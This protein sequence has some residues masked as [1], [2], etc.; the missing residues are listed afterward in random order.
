MVVTLFTTM[1]H[2]PDVP[3]IATSTTRAWRAQRLAHRRTGAGV[4]QR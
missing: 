4:S 1:S 2:S 3:M